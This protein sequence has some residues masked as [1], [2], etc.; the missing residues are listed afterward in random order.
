MIANY[1]ESK[2]RFTLHAPPGF[3]AAAH[4]VTAMRINPSRLRAA[5]C[6]AIRAPLV[7]HRLQLCRT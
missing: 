4:A 1:Y 2:T 6:R 3:R 5:A 7:Q